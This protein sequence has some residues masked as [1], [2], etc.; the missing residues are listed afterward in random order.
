MHLYIQGDNNGTDWAYSRNI[1]TKNETITIQ[2]INTACDLNLES[3]KNCKAWLETTENNLIYAKTFDVSKVELAI[4]IHIALK[5]EFGNKV[6]NISGITLTLKDSNGTIVTSNNDWE[7]TGNIFKS[8]NLYSGNYQLTVTINENN[9]SYMS[10]AGTFTI[11]KI[12]SIGPSSATD[13]N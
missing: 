4:P 13:P 5:D 8:K 9:S 10:P 2:D 1:A 6:T 7:Q 11:T 3:L 12:N